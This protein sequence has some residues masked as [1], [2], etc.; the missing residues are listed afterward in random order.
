MLEFFIKVSIFFSPELSKDSRE[1]F[2]FY[3]IKV[4]EKVGNSDS[5]CF[6]YNDEEELEESLFLDFN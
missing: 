2:E 1:V 4:S 5:L 6:L 3:F